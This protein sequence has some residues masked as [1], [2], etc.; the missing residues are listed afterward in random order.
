MLPRAA[1]ADPEAAAR[2]SA[3]HAALSADLADHARSKLRDK[4][5]DAIAANRVGV[6]GSG[7]E[8]AGNTLEVHWRDG[9]RTLGPAPKTTLA[10]MLLDLLAGLDAGGHRE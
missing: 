7:F 2:N 3:A 9:S 10:D 8:A 4:G 1:S 6:P 5:A